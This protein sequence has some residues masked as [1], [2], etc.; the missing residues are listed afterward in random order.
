[1]FAIK[2]YPLDCD[3]LLLYTKHDYLLAK[4]FTFEFF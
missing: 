2:F 1:M 3:E 4:K